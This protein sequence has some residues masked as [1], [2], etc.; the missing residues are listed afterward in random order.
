MSARRPYVRS[1]DGWWLQNPF[2]VR[3]MI[4]EATSLF[5]GAYALVLLAGLVCLAAGESVYNGWLAML[6]SPLAVVFHIAALVAVCY[7]VYTWFRV[8]PRVVPPTFV[9]G[10]RVK[11]N[12]IV[13]GQYAVLA[14]V[15][16]ILLLIAW[17][18]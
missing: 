1:M 6:R 18:A 16:L 9:G 4:R 17:N 14:V 8:A 13:A 11:D 3:Y 12:V 15:S 5:V 10:K 2:Y 7:H